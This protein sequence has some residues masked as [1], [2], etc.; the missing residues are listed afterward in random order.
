MEDDMNSKKSKTV[1][2]APGME[3]IRGGIDRL[4]YEAGCK[5]SHGAG[6]AAGAASGTGCACNNQTGTSDS[7]EA[8]RTKTLK[9]APP[10]I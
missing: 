9:M 8:L 1:L 4:L 2:L 7:I 5:C 6:T 3:L 10:L